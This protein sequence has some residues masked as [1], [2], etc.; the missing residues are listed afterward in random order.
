MA[1]TESAGDN[2]NDNNSDNDEDGCNL[3][4]YDNGTDSNRDNIMAKTMTGAVAVAEGV[5]PVCPVKTHC[6][7]DIRFQYYSLLR[8]FASTEA[9]QA[10][11]YLRLVNS[12]DVASQETWNPQPLQHH[13][14]QYPSM[15]SPLVL[16]FV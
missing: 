4:D 13:L 1:M 8:V 3:N 16:L 6:Q 7:Q 9:G 11:L 12:R 15:V 2:G 5:S 10:E 14:Y